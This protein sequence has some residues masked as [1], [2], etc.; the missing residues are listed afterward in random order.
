MSYNEDLAPV[1]VSLE[2]LWRWDTWL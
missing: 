1:L 2:E